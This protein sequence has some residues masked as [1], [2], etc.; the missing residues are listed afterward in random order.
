MSYQKIN[1]DDLNLFSKIVGKNNIFYSEEVLI[2]YSHD[3]TEDL[4][5]IP[6][7]VVK[8]N[9][10]EQVSE[11]MKYCNKNNIPVTPCGA[12]TGL[13]G[14]SLP[15]KSGVVLSSEKLNSILEID[16]RNLQATVEPGVINEVFQML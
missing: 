14:G 13:S 7:V 1:T 5:F 11:I 4:S 3:E 10:T 15:V 2:E 9:N 6:E 12:R 8:P 16:E